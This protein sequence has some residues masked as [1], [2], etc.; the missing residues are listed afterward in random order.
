[1]L[2]AG[3][4]IR[5]YLYIY[6]VY[7]DMVTI[8]SSYIS[9]KDTHYPMYTESFARLRISL[10]NNIRLL[11]AVAAYLSY[12]MVCFPFFS[13]CGMEFGCIIY[14]KISVNR[15]AMAMFCTCTF[16]TNSVCRVCFM[17]VAVLCFMPSYIVHRTSY[18]VV[19]HCVLNVVDWLFVRRSYAHTVNIFV[20]SHRAKEVQKG[21]SETKENNKLFYYDQGIRDRE[22]LL[23]SNSGTIDMELCGT[24]EKLKYYEILQKCSSHEKQT[25][26]LHIIMNQ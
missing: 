24:R 26:K 19:Y 17:C 11:G 25:T 21:E 7:M 5:I 14:M 23:N 2:A 18:I 1:M 13:S 20:F 22:E 3:I 9:Q 8:R 10:K 15:Y 12:S 16:G 4:T 6:T